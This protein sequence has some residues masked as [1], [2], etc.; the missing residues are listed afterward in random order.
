MVDPSVGLTMGHEA[1]GIIAAI[2]SSVTSVSVGDHVAIEPGQ[3][4]RYCRPCKSGTYHLCKNMRYG[5]PA[6]KKTIPIN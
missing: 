4:C 6:T 1:S 2:G 3:P 5:V